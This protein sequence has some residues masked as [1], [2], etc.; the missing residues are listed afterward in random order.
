[1][2]VR[3]AHAVAHETQTVIVSQQTIDLTVVHVGLPPRK[4]ELLRCSP[5]VV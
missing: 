4:E 2:W 1:M 3:Q 5:D